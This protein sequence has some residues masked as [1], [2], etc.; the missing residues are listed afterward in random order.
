MKALVGSWDTVPHKL[1]AEITALRSK[2]AQLTAENADLRAENAMLR[3]LRDATADV[4]EL[5][6]TSA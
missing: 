5:A 3:E 1:L 2:V 4:D 6:S